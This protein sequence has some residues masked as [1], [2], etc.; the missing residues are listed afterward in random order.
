[1]SRTN[2]SKSKWETSLYGGY[3][4]MVYDH[5]EVSL[6]YEV[7]ID[8]KKPG[9][10]S[11]YTSTK[12]IKIFLLK[13]NLNGI[14]DKL[15]FIE[16]EET[17]FGFTKRYLEVTSDSL[18]DVFTT[19]LSADSEYKNLF[20]HYKDEIL[21]SSIKMRVGN[22]DGNS[23]SDSSSE[24]NT[25]SENNK[26]S[27]AKK[28]KFKLLL[29]GI[30]EK[31]STSY[32]T[33]STGDFKEKTKFIHPESYG[34]CVFEKEEEFRAGQL[35]KMLDITFDPASDRINSLKT[36]KLDPRKIAQVPAGNTNVYYITEEDQ[37]TKPFSVVIL[38]DQSGSMDEN[39]KMYSAKNL[40]KTLYLAFSEILPPD[41]LY[42]YGHSGGY[43]PDIY[44]Y[45]DKYNQTFEDRCNSMGIEA[46]NY[47][48]PVIENIHAR[49]REMTDDNIIFIVLSDGAPEGYDYGTEK[50]IQELKQILEK[51]RRD[52]F[53]T[54]G[55]GI[56]NFHVEDLYTY[57][58]VIENLDYDMVKKTS[59]I[60]NRVVKTEFQ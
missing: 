46:Q 49:I 60:I 55:I 25:S 10:L 6:S 14:S 51:C 9:K 32:N 57:S 12:L 36:G 13:A 37:T 54:V 21:S 17:F 39:G 48:G 16:K 2:Y 5:P 50:H 19:L 40:V 33:L 31:K 28:E 30:K 35:V 4:R 26:T 8:V 29:S 47:D 27:V 38:V 24:K 56:Q 58:T 1:M 53:V 15:N 20:T 45:Q 44:V 7:D 3:S 43:T 59:H 11:W 18:Y 34:K 52:G 23:D 41:K 42:I 22:S